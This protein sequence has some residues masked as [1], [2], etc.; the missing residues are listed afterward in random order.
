MDPESDSDHPQNLITYSL[1]HVGHILKISS[2]SVH[3][4]LSYLSLKLHFMDQEDP[5]DPD[6]SKTK[7]ILPFTFSDIS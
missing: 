1:A 5:D 3:N 2:K 7:S 6:H 4:F